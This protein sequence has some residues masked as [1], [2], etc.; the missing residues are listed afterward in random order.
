[1]RY[2]ER[3][4]DAVF[5]VVQ[6]VVIVLAVVIFLAVLVAVFSRYVLND[7]VAWSEELPALLLANLTFLGA[8]LLCYKNEHLAFD[9][10][11]LS[12]PPRLQ[13][14]L[15]AA[16]LLLMAGFAALLLRYSSIVTLNYG[17]MELVTLPLPQ[18]LF[19]WMVPVSA[20]LMMMVFAL[21]FWRTVSGRGPSWEN[22]V[23]D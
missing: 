4:L 9:S 13:R 19:R 2:L 12:L 14:T 11:A 7:S 20:A 15:Y 18:Q 6:V 23:N 5:Q 16:N 17:A 3:G 21:K 1:M 22:Q 8:A 10:V